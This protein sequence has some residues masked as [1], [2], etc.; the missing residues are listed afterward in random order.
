[1]H[2]KSTIT[3]RVTEQEKIEQIQL[4]KRLKLTLSELLR[5]KLHIANKTE[6]TIF[7]TDWQTHNLLGEIKYHLR[8]IGVNVNQMARNL[9]LS[10]K[11]GNSV[12]L[13]CQKL[14]EMSDVITNTS[15]AI[16][17]IQSKIRNDR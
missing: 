17:E 14:I 16:T 8:K 11:M 1:M 2:L 4:A 6:V 7:K 13:Q 15:T 9:N 10:T 3:I 5:L 12:T